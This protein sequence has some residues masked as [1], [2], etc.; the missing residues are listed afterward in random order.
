MLGIITDISRGRN[1]SLEN[2]RDLVGP[3]F[4]LSFIRFKL[5]HY[6]CINL[7]P[8][9]LSPTNFAKNNS[10]HVH[11]KSFNIPKYAHG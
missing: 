2:F 6:A 1:R 10:G 11:W 3:R 7:Y 4:K 5:P 8:K 9:L